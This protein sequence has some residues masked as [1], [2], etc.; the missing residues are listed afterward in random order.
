MKRVGD[1]RAVLLDGFSDGLKGLYQ[2][3]GT[4]NGSMDDDMMGFVCFVKM[5]SFER[6]RGEESCLEP[7]KLMA[8]IL[9]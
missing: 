5:D 7:H 1:Q 2:H 6:E 3:A 9:V 4:C 8:W